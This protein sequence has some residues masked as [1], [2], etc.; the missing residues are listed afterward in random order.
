MIKQL[1]QSGFLYAFFSIFFLVI[2]VKAFYILK[3]IDKNLQIL[4]K[5]LKNSSK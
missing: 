3:N 5:N 2:T 1:F 4:T